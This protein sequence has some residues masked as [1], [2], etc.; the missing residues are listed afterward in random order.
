MW[1]V[2]L[3]AEKP[4]IRST[5]TYASPNT[6]KILPKTDHHHL[7]N[8]KLCRRPSLKHSPTH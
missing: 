8:P 6:K 2:Q 1:K 7:Q 5:C 3:G 4:M